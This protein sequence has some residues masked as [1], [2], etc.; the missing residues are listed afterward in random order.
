MVAPGTIPR[1]L[2]TTVEGPKEDVPVLP[3]LITLSSKEPTLITSQA[4][5][6]APSSF[7]PNLKAAL[8]DQLHKTITEQ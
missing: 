7:I 8:R 4:I 3:L 2:A 5:F 1:R 6:L